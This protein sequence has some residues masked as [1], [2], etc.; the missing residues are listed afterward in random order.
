MI[1][2][3]LAKLIDVKS[4][5]SLALTFVF[6][7]LAI[8]GIIAPELFI[9]IFTTVIAFYF[10]TQYQKKTQQNNTAENA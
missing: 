4:I 7:Y 5:I 1:K 8:M 9:P 2:E 10:G 3:K 6:C